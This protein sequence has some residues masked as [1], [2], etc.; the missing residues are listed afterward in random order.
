M[1]VTDDVFGPQK[2]RE[3]QKYS[4]SGALDCSIAEY[5]D[6]APPKRSK[7][8]R[9]W[10]CGNRLQSGRGVRRVIDGHERD[11]HKFCSEQDKKKEDRS[12]KV[13]G[14]EY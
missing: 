6:E 8:K 2:D 13:Y 5:L 14:M 9:C 11:L 12:D 3:R 10:I 4:N 7:A 1:G